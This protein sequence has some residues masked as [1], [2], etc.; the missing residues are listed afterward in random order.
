MTLID[1]S[2]WSQLGKLLQTVDARIGAAPEGSGFWRFAAES[3]GVQMRAHE[4][5]AY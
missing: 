3:G 1:R 4:V 2:V 5:P